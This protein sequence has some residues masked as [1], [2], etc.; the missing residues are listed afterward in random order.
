MAIWPEAKPAWNQPR[1]DVT[2]PRSFSNV[3]IASQL[4]VF[5]ENKL[6]HL[7]DDLWTKIVG[8]EAWLL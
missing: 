3:T 2:W 6:D 7:D 4:G 1:Q 5:F 8:P